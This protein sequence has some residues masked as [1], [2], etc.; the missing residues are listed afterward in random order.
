MALCCRF[1]ETTMIQPRG[2]ALSAE[3]PIQF[4][5]ATIDD[6]A[7]IFRSALLTG[8]HR[9]FSCSPNE[10]GSWRITVWDG[11]AEP[12]VTPETKD[13]LRRVQQGEQA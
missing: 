5:A 8:F 11:T 9:D 12:P 13:A 7:E 1:P 3:L 10:D 2:E 6:A 4:R